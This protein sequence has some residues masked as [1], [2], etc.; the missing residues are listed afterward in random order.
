MAMKRN[1]HI[2]DKCAAKK[3]VYNI[4]KVKSKTEL[5]G[6]S[7]KTLWMGIKKSL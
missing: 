5:V 4:S 1:K 7:F 2:I 3:R 6:K